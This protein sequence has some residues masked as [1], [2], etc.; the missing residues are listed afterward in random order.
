MSSSQFCF[1]RVCKEREHLNNVLH[2]SPN[3]ALQKHETDSHFFYTLISSFI[4]CINEAAVVI[5]SRAS[6]LSLSSQSFDDGH[7][8]VGSQKPSAQFSRLVWLF[9]HLRTGGW[10][11]TRRRL[12]PLYWRPPLLL[13]LSQFQWRWVPQTLGV[14]PGIFL[15]NDSFRLRLR[16]RIYLLVCY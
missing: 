15:V 4:G 8:D 7:D 14:A 5:Q 6:V 12:L 9:T 1:S 11:Q 10:F 2:W 13:L 16:V 3:S